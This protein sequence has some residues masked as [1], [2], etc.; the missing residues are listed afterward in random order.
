MIELGLANYTSVSPAP[1]PEVRSYTNLILD[2]ILSSAAGSSSGSSGATAALEMAASRWARALATARVSHPSITPALLADI[3]RA[4]CR[5]GEIVYDL[6]VDPVR[7]LTFLP[8]ADWTVYG[9]AARSSWWYR[10]SLMGPSGNITVERESDGVAHFM[11]SYTARQPW[12]G[13]GPLQWASA[14]G[15]LSGHVEAALRDEASGPRGSIVPLPE[16]AKAQSGLKTSFAAL[17]GGLALPETTA[18]GSGDRAQSP[19]RDWVVSR[20][21]ANPPAALVALRQAVEVS[22]LSTCGVPPALAIGVTDGTAMREAYRQF[23]HLTVKPLGRIVETTFSDVLGSPVSLTFD[24]LSAAD[25][26]SRARAWRA[27]VGR[28]A[29]MDEAEAA[30]IVGFTE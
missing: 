14:T 3:G 11:Y 30:R 21:G 13:L 18:G 8:V 16:G 1:A 12:R 20:I 6:V 23:L 27:L 19:Q 4:L 28:E 9:G 22:T 26:Q 7:G 5:S 15:S 29:S 10:L 24:E 25:I 2:A 17:K